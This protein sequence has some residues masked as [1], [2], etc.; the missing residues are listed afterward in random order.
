MLYRYV[1]A[2]EL[3]LQKLSREDIAD[4]TL[5]ADMYMIP[6]LVKKG[7]KRLIPS[8]IEEVFPPLTVVSFIAN[9]ELEP[10]VAK[11]S[12]KEHKILAGKC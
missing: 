12:G 8:N 3:G 11:V 5:A 6:R 9:T 7:C 10:H 1:N 2:G 4:L